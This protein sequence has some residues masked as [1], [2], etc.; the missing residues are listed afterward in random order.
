MEGAPF[1]CREFHHAYWDFNWGQSWTEPEFLANIRILDKAVASLND[2]QTEYPKTDLLIIYGN[3]AQN[4]WY[5]DHEARNVWDI[6][7]KLHILDKCE[8]IWQ[9]GYRCAL[10]PDY[11][12]TDGRTR[13]EGNTINFNGHGFTHLLFLYPK[14]AKKEVYKFLNDANSA[15]IP[16]AVVGRCD[17][18][19][20]AEN[21]VMNAPHYDEFS[22]SLLEEIGC[23]KSAIEGGCIYADGSFALVSHGILTGENISFD[24]KVD[25]VR[26]SGHHSGILAYRK[27]QVAFATKGSKLLADGEEIKLSIVKK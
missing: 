18:D 15:G 9:A 13:I 5:P 22:L 23:P 19:F 10:V 1:G 17:I 12:I 26:Y 2:F 4:N 16:M 6:D 11:T 24:F 3:S 25:G 7:G 14:Y 27:G 20:D 8:D 21:V